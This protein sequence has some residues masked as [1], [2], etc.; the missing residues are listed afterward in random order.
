M[1][2][3]LIKLKEHK[4][5][6]AKK[7]DKLAE[8]KKQQERLRDEAAQLEAELLKFAQEDLSNTKYKSVTYEGTHNNAMATVADSVKI[9]YESFLPL[10]F[11]TAYEDMTKITTKVELTAPAK[12]LIAG[13]WLGNYDSRSTV[14]TVIKSMCLDE[15]TH[16]LVVKK[17]KGVNYQKDVDNLIAVAGYTEQEAQEYAYMLMEAAIWQQ[18]T[19]LMQVNGI[20]DEAKIQDII[21]KIQAAFIVEQTTKITLEG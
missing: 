1:S 2:D 12:R 7:I 15:K 18:F 8:I 13:I 9:T 14:D 3:S 5:I 20:T 11:G 16:K 17:C 19:A 6:I 21:S 10:I 4:D